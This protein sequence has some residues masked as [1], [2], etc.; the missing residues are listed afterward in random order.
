MSQLLRRFLLLA[1]FFIGATQVAK[2]EVRQMI[3]LGSSQTCG[4]WTA[5][6][7]K[8]EHGSMTP[9]ASGIAAWSLGFLSGINLVNKGSNLLETV[10]AEAIW[11][12][13]DNYC[14]AHPRISR[15]VSTSLRSAASTPAQ[16]TGYRW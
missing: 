1:I 9:M 12:W 8:S 15:C 7:K 3:G 10:D 11:A 13:L 5:E 16:R 2:A 14:A 4:T 6:R